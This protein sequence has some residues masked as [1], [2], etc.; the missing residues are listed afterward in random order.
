MTTAA[1]FRSDTKMRSS[2]I[3]LKLKI[4]DGEKPKS[5]T[6]LVDHRLFKGDNNLHVILDPQTMFYSFKMDHGILPEPFRQRFTGLSKAISFAK[7]YF[8]TR[9]VE[10]TEVLD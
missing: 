10:V 5:A 8:E 9:N 7:E 1:N 6:G 3:V 4:K 2:D